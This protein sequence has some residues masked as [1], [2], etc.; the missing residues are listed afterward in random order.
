MGQKSGVISIFA[1]A[2]T[3]A[4]KTGGARF[5]KTLIREP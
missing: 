4:L 5:G 3:G 1:A 2:I